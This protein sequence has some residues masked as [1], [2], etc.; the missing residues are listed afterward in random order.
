MQLNELSATQDTDNAGLGLILYEMHSGNKYTLRAP[1]VSVR[2]A[3]YSRVH[4]L[5]SANKIKKDTLRRAASEPG[6]PMGRSPSIPR[7]SV[8]GVR[9]EP[10]KKSKHMQL[11]GVLSNPSSV[12]ATDDTE[13]T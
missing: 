11:E 12:V 6:D 9:R 3:W 5:I 13:V 4:E 7:K 1:S 2:D 10:T 8:F